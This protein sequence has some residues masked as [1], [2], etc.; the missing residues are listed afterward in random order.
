MTELRCSITAP[1]SNVL[2]AVS[3]IELPR[4]LQLI[5][6]KLKWR[7]NLVAG[8]QTQ[9][10]IILKAVSLGYSEVKTSAGYYL[11]GE[12]IQG[13]ALGKGNAFTD[14]IIDPEQ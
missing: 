13:R 10:K 1:E 7:G 8:E 14:L 6:G 3:D 9:R 4:G 11:A 2:D 12:Y 5:G